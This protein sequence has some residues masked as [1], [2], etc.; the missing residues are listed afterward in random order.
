M[1]TPKNLSSESPH[2]N[3]YREKKIAPVRQLGKIS[4]ICAYRSELYRQL[5]IHSLTIKGA[6]ILE[7]AF[8]TGQNSLCLAVHLPNSLSLVDPNPTGVEFARDLYGAVKIKHTIPKI[9]ESRLEDFEPTS[10]FDIVICEN[11]LGNSKY[12]RELFS[13]LMRFGKK[14]SFLITT[15]ISP[16]GIL[17]NLLRRIVSYRI[18]HDCSE[19]E[20]SSKLVDLWS[21][22]LKTMTSMTRSHS[23]WVIDN[24]I[25][26]AYRGILVTPVDIAQQASYDFNIH[27]TYPKFAQDFTWFKQ[28]P[29]DPTEELSWFENEYYE[30]C[31]TFLHYSLPH[32]RGESATNRNLD[33]DSKRLFSAVAKWE[34]AAVCDRSHLW[35]SITKLLESIASQIKQIYPRDLSDMVRKSID[36]TIKPN[37]DLNAIKSCDS[38]GNWFGRET[39]YLS[40]VKR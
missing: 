8:G 10:K 6:D 19:S 32:V 34:V 30:N 37:L 29:R 18:A 38:F 5:G 11:W 7:V 40:M 27:A 13:R 21:P 15:A 35:Q 2:L 16:I 28:L 14:D 25:N 22:H 1:L 33:R 24:L 17:P 36:H 39:I 23:D 12:D 3:F 20:I 26:P 4:D 31:H 9:Q